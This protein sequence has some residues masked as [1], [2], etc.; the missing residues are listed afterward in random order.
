MAKHHAPDIKATLMATVQA[1]LNAIQDEI[2]QHETTLK[3][4]EQTIAE[5]EDG[6]QTTSAEVK[7]LHGTVDMLKDWIDDLENKSRRNNL[8]L[9]SLHKSVPVSTLK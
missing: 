2:A 7:Q 3:E 5:A 4:A 9:I 6:L 8:W 1:T